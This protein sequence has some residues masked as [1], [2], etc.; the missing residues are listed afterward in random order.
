ME[1]KVYWNHKGM[2]FNGSADS[3]GV[4]H[5]SSALDG[6]RSGFRPMELL[7]IGL[8][9]CTAM[10]VISILTKKKQDVQDFE[11]IVHT[12][13]SEEHPK[14]WNWVQIEYVVTGRNIDPRAVERAMELSSQ[15]YC[16]AQSMIGKAVNIELIYRIIEMDQDKG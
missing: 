14:V 13:N 10:D 12:R 5:L 1:A 15:K 9:G 8:A 2:Q 3:G 11:V 4:L 16:P 6:G 7:G